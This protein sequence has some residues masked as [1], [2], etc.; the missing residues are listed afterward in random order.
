MGE[1]TVL[2]ATDSCPNDVGWI[3]QCP[4]HERIASGIFYGQDNGQHPRAVV[5]EAV[6]EGIPTFHIN[7]K[8]Y[9]L[10]I[11][12]EGAISASIVARA[13]DK[14]RTGSRRVHV[15]VEAGVEDEI[16]PVVTLRRSDR[17]GP[18]ES[19]VV[20]IWQRAARHIWRRD[21]EIDVDRCRV[22]A[23]GER[24]T[25]ATPEG[26][27]VA[28]E[29]FGVVGADLRG[30]PSVPVGTLIASTHPPKP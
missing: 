23:W 16:A 27:R 2:I 6:L 18:V 3:A 25:F 30:T 28:I 24:P 20:R 10:R 14:A 4:C 11:L 22:P 13:N 12:R 1:P 5:A 21:V 26:I 17:R 8:G 9:P 7:R 19:C 29:I 15:G